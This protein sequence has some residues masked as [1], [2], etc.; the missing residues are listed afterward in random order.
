MG[1]G[2]KLKDTRSNRNIIH[3][4]LPY[5]QHNFDISVTTTTTTA[6]TTTTLPNIIKSNIIYTEYNLIWP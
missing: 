3:V 5:E 2:S 4:E 6:T 1:K